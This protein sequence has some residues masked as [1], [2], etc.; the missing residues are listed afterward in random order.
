MHSISAIN[1]GWSLPDGS[2]LFENLEFHFA[3]ER[4]GLVGANGS[5]KSTLLRILAGDLI[6]GSGSVRVRGSVAMVPQDVE[7]FRQGKVADALGVTGLWN[8]W[9]RVRGGE[10][11]PED[12]DA[13]Q[14]HWDLEER[15][16][17]ALDRRRL[18]H[19]A[20]DRSCENLSGGEL[21]RV[22]FAG[23]MLRK[24]DFLILDEP[25]N[26]LDQ[27]SRAD[28][29]D[30]IRGWSGGLLVAS[31]DRGLLR[32]VDRIAELSPAGLRLYGGGYDF[33]RQT[34]EGEDAA[35]A[36]EVEARA[37]GLRRDRL[38]R[39]RTLERQSKRS[40]RGAKNAAGLGLPK[41][42]LG[43]MKRSAEESSARLGKVHEDRVERSREALSRARSR[44]REDARIV[45]DPAGASVPGRKTLLRAEAVNLRFPDGS[46]LWRLPVDMEIRGPERVGLAG[47][48][49]SGKS[50]LL[51][52]LRGRLLPTSGRVTADVRRIGLLDQ[53][54]SFLDATRSVFEN[55]RAHAAP[56]LSDAEL[57]IRLG[58]FHFPGKHALKPA[59][60][61][62]GGERMRAGLACLL[63]SG[64]EMDLLMLDE[65]GNN[66]D[67]TA[68]EALESALDAY[69]G[70]VIVVSHDSGFLERIGPERFLSLERVTAGRSNR[71]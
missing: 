63:A 31:H 69:R 29:E 64:R 57:R 60:V 13:L 62:S 4:I 15:C 40:A 43:M 25:S 22:V 71:P 54:V 37:A 24:A 23:A 52:M 3:A 35:A 48:N 19:L 5:G 28:L 17:E 34:R 8:A 70:A 42:M 49:G 2:P 67:F 68:R 44:V 18:G 7:G 6:P 56:E 1:L 61:L 20:P 26:H 16:L 9:T 33:Y 66:L 21:L 27:Q 51:A 41:I 39:Q 38:E 36:A 55:L 10:A 53:A 30:L 46:W 50:L 14:G 59:G 58:R 12:A 47:G 11:A 45:M 32:A 65:P